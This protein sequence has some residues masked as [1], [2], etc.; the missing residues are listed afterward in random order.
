MEKYD[1]YFL[2]GW[3]SQKKE[4]DFISLVSQKILQKRVKTKGL[5]IHL[6]HFPKDLN[7]S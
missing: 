4:N 2:R 1:I 5:K 6:T 3:I 7:N